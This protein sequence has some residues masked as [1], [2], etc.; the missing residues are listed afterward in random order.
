M[1][2]KKINDDLIQYHFEINK[3][4]FDV[5]VEEIY[6]KV[7]S[8]VELKGFRKGFVTRDMY[9]KHFDPRSLY[10]DA[11]SF[12]VQKKLK[13][14]FEQN[15]EYDI[16]GEPKIINFNPE[17]L[18]KKKD[19]FN[20]G[21]EFMLK[22][23][24]KVCNYKNIPAKN[25]NLEITDE[26][27][28]KKIDVLFKNDPI[29]ES[30]EKDSSLE[31]GDFA[32]F[33]FKGYLNDQLFEGG[34]ATNYTLEIGSNQF[35]PGFETGMIALKRNEEKDINICFPTDYAKEEL[36]GKEVVFKVLLHDIKRKKDVVLNDE[37]V[38]SMKFPNINNVS[39]FK[40]K[41]K[42]ELEIQKKYEVENKRKEE[43]LEFLV[44][45]SN[46]KI[47]QFLIDEEAKNLKKELEEELKSKKVSLEEYL[48]QTKLDETKFS[49]EMQEQALNKIKLNFLLDEIG[50]KEKIEISSEELEA[51]CQQVSTEYKTDIQI[52]KTNSYFVKN[53]KD[54]LIRQKVVDFLVKNNDK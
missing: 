17:D 40:K 48:K 8:K 20:F 21:I 42:E 24:I 2:I 30:K 39:E 15:K 22:P 37:L 1:Q 29:L 18:L 34:S 35:I 23:E 46:L 36:A 19:F 14:I 5:F 43:I 41:I 50:T 25:Y 28:E 49:Q 47:S 44:Q 52:I 31:S 3:D 6:N 16:I 10:D 53:I 12:L 13:K 26:E 54:Y 33:D 11:F 27:V 38:K 51:T 45:K 4:D 9:E 32:I 7:K